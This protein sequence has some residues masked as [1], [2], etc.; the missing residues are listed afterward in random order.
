M[1]Y[2]LKDKNKIKTY[3][4]N[5]GKHFPN[6]CG[7]II[8][9]IRGVSNKDNIK[10]DTKFTLLCYSCSDEKKYTQCIIYN[11]DL[12]SFV[13][14]NDNVEEVKEP[15]DYLYEAGF[16]KLIRSSNKTILIEEDGTK[17]ITT[18]QDGDKDDPEKAVMILL[19]KAAGYTVEEIYSIISLIK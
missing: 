1:Y 9:L 18:L 13:T 7:E 4:V 11:K 17:Y 15:L 8:D 10:D 12:G 19:L 14:F 16:K 5:F 6:S 3:I 2:K